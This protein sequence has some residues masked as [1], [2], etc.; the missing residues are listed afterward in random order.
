LLSVD[1]K[2]LNPS[3]EKKPGESETTD[4]FLNNEDFLFKEV[5]GVSLG[6]LGVVT[7]V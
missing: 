6:A 7:R 2:I 3:W 1:T 5:R 4:L